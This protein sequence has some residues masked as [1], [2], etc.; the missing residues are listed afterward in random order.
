MKK[1]SFFCLILFFCFAKFF[2]ATEP[3]AE[4]LTVGVPKDRCP[5]FYQDKS[6]GEIIG[7]GI[8]LMRVAA[9]NAGY[10]AVFKLMDEPSLKEALDSTDYDVI[11]PFGSAI[12]SASGRDS[13]VS[14]NL[15]QTPFT[16]VTKGKQKLPAINN[17]RVGMLQSLA[18]VAET[19][20][21]LYDG[22]EIEFFK[23]MEDGVKA[24]R[25]GKIDSLLHNSYVWSYILQKPSYADLSVQPLSMFSM[26]FR[27]GAIS[28]AENSAIIERL[29]SGIHSLS[30]T[31]KQAIILDYTSRRLYRYDF[32]DY[33]YQYGVFFVLI[34]LLATAIVVIVL[35][36][37]NTV[38]L[39]SEEKLRHLINHDFLTGSLSLTGFRNRVEELLRLHPEK[40]YIIAYSNIKNFK[41]INESL[42]MTAGNGLL[43][44]LADKFMENLSE[45]DAIGRIEADHFAVLRH[46]DSKSRLKKYE[47]E[48]YEP[49]RNYF[50]DRGEETRVQIC[51]GIY[52]LTP[53]DYQNINADQMLDFAR[54]AEKRL[55][56]NHKEGFCFYNSEQWK[57]G[58]LVADMINHLPMAIQ[59]KE[60]QVWYQPQVDFETGKIIG[61]EALCRWQLARR[62]WISPVEFIPALEEAGLIYELDC[63]VWEKVCQDL[64]RWNASGKRR[65]VSVN[66]SRADFAKDTDIPEHFH[67]LV[68]AYELN[69]SQ[70]HIEITETAYVENP[71]HLISTTHRLRNFGFQVEMDDFGS[72][73]SS[74]NMLKEVQ[75]D[76]I[77]LDLHFLTETGD[78]DKG[79]IIINHIIK[80]AQSLGMNIIAEGVESAEQAHFLK[81]LGCNEMQGFYF[82]KPMPTSDFEKLLETQ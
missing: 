62:G 78:H 34:L 76:R 29:N 73:Y 79:R 52:A 2:F 17:L 8:D 49:A 82:H 75:V 43:R 4:K 40:S 81:D 72:G 51:T 36:R 56:E 16:I 15:F 57:S 32:S 26:D 30:D 37:M 6:S 24:L 35:L 9:E 74:L 47:T 63:F 12:K 50:I 5:I 14:D 1:K 3:Q 64:K 19:V 67:N 68:Q 41:Y 22:M 39:K 55:R 38:R 58:K 10:S 65:S 53:A 7:I 25:A 31:Q 80:M 69:P 60:I 66:L 23:T 44:F 11:M 21:E 18:G 61:A 59:S 28:S 42:G 27:A 54:V 77:K 48:V 70:L 71:E 33:L 45:E 46:L 13:I 20:R